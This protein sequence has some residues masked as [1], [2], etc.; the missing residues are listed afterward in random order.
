MAG[1]YDIIILQDLFSEMG[2]KEASIGTTSCFHDFAAANSVKKGV[3]IQEMEAAAI[4]KIAYIMNIP[5]FA[6]KIVA[7]LNYGKEQIEDITKNYFEHVS[8]ES[9]LLAGVLKKMLEKMS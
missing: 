2:F 8:E 6:L 9:E 5:F 1:K 4:Q 3:Y 7:S